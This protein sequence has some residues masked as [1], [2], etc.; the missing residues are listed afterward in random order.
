MG[1][2]FVSGFKLDEQQVNVG[3][4]E[5]K[6][7]KEVAADLGLDMSGRVWIVNGK[8]LSDTEVR[9]ARIKTGDKVKTGAKSDQGVGN[10]ATVAH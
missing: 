10:G 2:A 6:S 1:N 3:G 4:S 9:E 7:I 5:G 8:R